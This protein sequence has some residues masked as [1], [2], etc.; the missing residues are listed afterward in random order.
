MKTNK[1]FEAKT[2][3]ELE[4]IE[5]FLFDLKK[6]C[7]TEQVDENTKLIHYE[8]DEEGCNCGSV[9]F[10]FWRWSKS[11]LVLTA[12]FKWWVLNEHLERL[13]GYPGSDEDISYDLDEKLDMLIENKEINTPEKKDALN[14]LYKAYKTLFDQMDYKVVKNKIET[15]FNALNVLGIRN[16]IK[17]YDNYLD[18]LELVKEHGTEISK[19]SNRKTFQND[20]GC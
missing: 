6:A 17:V 10:S 12:Y 15:I 2:I 14:D 13:C 3:E 18:A 11:L 5:G 8:V 4:S 16:E 20:A 9:T 7:E 1:I 19:R